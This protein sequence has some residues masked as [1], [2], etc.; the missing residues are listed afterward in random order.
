[1]IAVSSFS[2]SRVQ[3][4]Y[5]AA[6]ALKRA[7]IPLPPSPFAT[8]LAA[9]L[10][11]EKFLSA[12]ARPLDRASLN[13]IAVQYRFLALRVAKQLYEW[14]F[15]R[16]SG[17]FDDV[18]QECL[19]ALMVAVEK[20]DPGRKTRFLT[21]AYPTLLKNGIRVAQNRAYIVRVPNYASSAL[22]ATEGKVPWQMRRELP[23]DI[24]ADVVRAMNPM[25]F[26]SEDRCRD[27]V[28]GGGSGEFFRPMI[29]EGQVSDNCRA[30]RRLGFRDV[31]GCTLED[32]NEAFGSLTELE[33]ELLRE[34]FW[35]GKH[36]REIAE[37]RG[38]LPGAVRAR[39]SRAMEKMRKI[40]EARATETAKSAARAPA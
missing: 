36:Y 1:M 20:F 33:Q 3:P 21:Y 39:V 2:T 19:I 24:R 32:F 27:D 16:R 10:T 38:W 9:G 34:R 4:D 12:S 22:M 14:D 30:G 6:A 8:A 28:S 35:E 25:W 29:S 17:T 37:A 15:V 7:S 40:L 11:I 13:A 31:R 26:G 5:T 18:V 23:A